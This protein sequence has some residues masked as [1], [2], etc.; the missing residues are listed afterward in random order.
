MITTLK[1]RVIEKKN[2][3]RNCTKNAHTSVEFIYEFLSPPNFM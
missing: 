1:T 2:T 3:R